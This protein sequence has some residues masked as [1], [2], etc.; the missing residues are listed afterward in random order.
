MTVSQ[1]EQQSEERNTAVAVPSQLQQWEPAPSSRL[2]QF[3]A[4]GKAAYQIALSVANTPFV[5]NSYKQTGNRNNRRYLEPP[6]IAKNVTAAWLAGDEIGLK[7]MQALQAIDIIEGRPALN[8]LAMRALVQAAG[9]EVWVSEQIL[10]TGSQRMQISVT[11]RGRR[12]G[13]DHVAEST[14][15]LDRARQAGLLDKDNWQNH[16]L[17]M[18][19]ARGTSDVCRQVAA[20]VLMGLAYSAEELNDGVETGIP[21]GG[22][23]EVSI[24]RQQPTQQQEQGNVVKVPEIAEPSEEDIDR[25]H[26]TVAAAVEREKQEEA[27]RPEPCPFPG[28]ELAADHEGDH[29]EA[30]Q[31]QPEPEPSLC[32][33]VK[34]DD[35]TRACSREAEH[36]GRHY[37][38]RESTEQERATEQP[39]AAKPPIADPETTEPAPD[40]SLAFEQPEQPADE[41][42]YVEPTEEEQAR[43]YEEEQAER[44]RKRAQEDAER[45]RR[46]QEAEKKDGP[47]PVAPAAAAAPADEV[48]LPEEPAGD[49]PWA[50]FQ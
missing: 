23:N 16:P 5:P 35:P 2:Q 37:Y 39:A 30:E 41:P 6:E 13:S 14:W 25:L 15:S 20:D 7:P 38:G 12:S 24:Q 43:A 22:S 34:P 11:V 45:E 46:A 18:C 42:L 36:S 4:D 47:A 48:P 9:H 26:Q 10:G 31:A 28:C 40:P 3:A 21:K 50:D 44:E 19:I 33:Q 1:V 32:S 49:D 29:R 17:Q 8:A 27:G